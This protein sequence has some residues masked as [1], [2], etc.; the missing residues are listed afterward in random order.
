LEANYYIKNGL[1]PIAFSEQELLDC[2]TVGGNGCTGGLPNHAFTFV[3]TCGV[4]SS[5]DYPYTS[6]SSGVNGTCAENKQKTSY[7]N[8]NYTYCTNN[9]TVGEQR[10]P[11]TL[12]T[13]QSIL[14][15]GPGAVLLEASSN[16][17]K[18][19]ASGVLTLTSADCSSGSDHAAIAVGWG[20]DSS[21]GLTYVKV[22]NSW[23]SSWGE[24]GYVRVQYDY[25]INDTC[26]ITRSIFRPNF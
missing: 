8:V 1:T 21:T 9:M 5:A 2:G 15:V 24:G 16:D 12:S 6:G 3:S 22:R 7:K 26:Y 14:A 11:C 10:S 4:E 18:N 20:V 23:G 19:Y 13:W 25:S 17:F